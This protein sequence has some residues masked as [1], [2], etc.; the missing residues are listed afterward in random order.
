MLGGGGGGGWGKEED[1]EVQLRSLS[2]RLMERPESAVC[3]GE[4][5]S[6][7]CKKKRNSGGFSKYNLFILIYISKI[8][9]DLT[10]IENLQIKDI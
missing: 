10:R 7:H 6:Q 9:L 5:L 1:G 4:I 2:S 8:L 3:F